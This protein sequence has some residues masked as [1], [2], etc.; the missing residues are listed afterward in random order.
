[1]S[2]SHSGKLSDG[3]FGK[4]Q[5]L[6]GTDFEVSGRKERNLNSARSSKGRENYF[7]PPGKGIFQKAQPS[8][9]FLFYCFFTR[10]YCLFYLDSKL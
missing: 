2:A 10:D 8:V 3:T 4:F 1:M 5:S 7:R 9:Y 6:S